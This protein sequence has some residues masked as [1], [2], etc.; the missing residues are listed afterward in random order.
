[1]RRANALA[2]LIALG[3][4]AGCVDEPASK[5]T[6]PAR[7]TRADPEAV[8]DVL[9]AISDRLA[10]VSDYHYRG[11]AENIADGQ[12]LHFS[13][14][15]SQPQRLRADLEGAETTFLF[16]GVWLAVIDRPNQRVLKQDLTKKD[17]ATLIATLHQMFGSYSVEGWRPPL[18]RTSREALSGHKAQDGRGPLWVVAADVEDEALAEVRYYLRPPRADFVKKEYIDKDGSV[19]SYAKVLEEY[20]DERTG[21]RFPIAWEHKDARRHYR[22]RLEAPAVNQGVDP[23]RFAVE[24]PGGFTVQEFGAGG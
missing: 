21:L 22:V 13:Y 1:M 7:L 11:V 23:A 12:K 16:D 10:K 6:A 3:P 9:A 14:T 24:V 2:I 5:A 15:L 8:S 19:V 17:E 4:G 18:L 20:T